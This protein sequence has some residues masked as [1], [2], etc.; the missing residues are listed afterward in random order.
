MKILLV[1]LFISLSFA[2]PSLGDLIEDVCRNSNNYKFCVKALRADP[3]SSSAVQKGLTRIMLQLSLAKAKNI[4]NEVLIL[5][6]QTEEAVLKQRLQICKDNYDG[7]VDHITSSIEYL[8]ANDFFSAA[9]FATDVVDD[10]SS[11]EES[12]TEPPIRKSSLKPKSDEFLH[13]AVITVTLIHLLDN[14]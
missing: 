3:K 13:F 10:S 14:L 9:S 6:N 11:C 5:L 12:F 4:Y 2:N 8:D 1:I 7:A